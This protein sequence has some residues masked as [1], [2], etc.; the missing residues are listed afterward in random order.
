MSKD[1]FRRIK[2]LMERMD[3][4]KHIEHDKTKDHRIRLKE[5]IGD[6]TYGII[7][8]GSSFVIKMANKVK[9]LVVEDFE[10]IGGIQNKNKFAHESYNK[11]LT[12]LQ[13]QLKEEK[14]VMKQSSPKPSFNSPPTDDFDNSGEGVEDATDEDFVDDM[15]GGEDGD[16]DFKK[17]VGS[18]LADFDDADVD[19][20][21]WLLNSLIAKMVMPD[22]EE[23]ID[24][25]QSKLNNV[26]GDTDESSEGDFE[27]DAIEENFTIT[28]SMSKKEFLTKMGK[29]S[30][31]PFTE[32]PV[33][34]IEGLTTEPNINKGVKVGKVK[35]GIFGAK[36]NPNVVKGGKIFSENKEDGIFTEPVKGAT[37]GASVKKAASDQKEGD[38]KKAK[39]IFQDYVPPVNT[40]KI[41]EGTDNPNSPFGDTKDT[42][43]NDKKHLT[44]FREE[45]WSTDVV[46]GETKYEKEAIGIE[47]YGSEKKIFDDAT[48]IENTTPKNVV[49]TLG[50]PKNGYI[51][52]DY[53]FTDVQ[54]M[55]LKEADEVM[56]AILNSD[57]EDEEFD[58]G[59]LTSE[60][61]L[62]S[63]EI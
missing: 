14:Y 9:D 43:V 51:Q 56:D 23:A 48:A 12:K 24:S 62:T 6:K 11:A 54:N 36:E 32:K 1:K 46:N 58:Y 18:M 35:S 60:A 7:K 29:Q 5:S 53:Q 57:N 41:F 47:R 52:N 37:K 13:L 38:V 45:L 4:S 21:K 61:Y 22:D 63:D 30:A 28:E 31:A 40:G 33:K 20:K 8:E 16:S 26:E 19:D 59:K 10:Y 27:G 34:E 15:D 39:T 17:K 3:T 44:A 55:S 2:F 25:A 49:N 42:L 50:K